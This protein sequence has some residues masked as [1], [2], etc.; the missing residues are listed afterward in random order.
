M[1]AVYVGDQRFIGIQDSILL[2]SA[3]VLF[4][5]GGTQ[6][7]AQVWVGGQ[8]VNV[9]MADQDTRDVRLAVRLQSNQGRGRVEAVA[10]DRVP[11]K[12]RNE[13]LQVNGFAPWK[14]AEPW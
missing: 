2:V 9:A 4:M 5:A 14:I 11:F 6:P 7:A 8:V 12:P 3:N 10:E 13:C 1:V